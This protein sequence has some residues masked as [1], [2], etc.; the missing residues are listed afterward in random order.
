MPI[1]RR[2][3]HLFGTLCAFDTLPAEVDDGQLE[4]LDL[5]AGLIAFE[6]EADEEQQQ[7]RADEARR[8]ALLLE[9][10]TFVDACAHDLKGPLSVIQGQVQLLRRRLR[11][12]VWDASPTSKSEAI[13]PGLA[14]IETSS[15]RMT[16]LIDEL[17]DAANLQEGRSLNLRI[18]PA[19]LVEIVATVADAARQTDGG[20]RIRFESAVPEMVGAWDRA[21][22]E[23]VVGNILGN[24]VK[25]SPDGG[26]IVV[27]LDAVDDV[28]G[29]WAVMTV[30]DHGIGIPAADLPRVFDRFHRGGNV[31]AIAGSGIGLAG[32]RQIVEQH[33]GT[34]TATSAEHAGSTFTLRLPRSGPADG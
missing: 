28:T 1:F 9:R 29:G 30:T 33:G 20:D 14:A 5:L 18:A 24:A 4:I 16:A 7:R 17:L 19:D 11:R 15:V 22:L 10:K 13:D 6:L 25:Y 26:E 2:D 21:R 3:G 12:A 27:R 34:L 32:S 8:R 23:R 31:G